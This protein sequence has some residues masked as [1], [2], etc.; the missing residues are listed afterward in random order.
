MISLI[1]NNS[2]IFEIKDKMTTFEYYYHILSNKNDI[3][4]DTISIVMTSSN[5]SKQT[6][7]T[8]NSFKNSLYKNIHVVLVDDSTS[9]PIDFKI[10]SDYPFS[11]DF[12][13]IKRDKKIWVNPCVN[14]NIGF[15]FVKGGKVIIQNAEV[16]HVGDVLSYVNNNVNDSSYYI[17]D[18]KSS[19]GYPSN[20]ELY[21]TVYHTIDTY[22]NT[23]LFNPGIAGWYQSSKYNNR[24]LHFLTAMTLE[25]F[26]LIGGFS[27]D[28]SF[29][30]SYDDNDLVLKIDA[31]NIPTVSVNN[32][33]S[34]C[35]GIHLY[36]VLAG[37]DWE[38][39]IEQ[40]KD[41]FELKM[42]YFNVNKS[43]IEV[44]ESREAYEDNIRK[45]LG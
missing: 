7:Y 2:R 42:Q 14:Y 6:Y 44:T 17:F 26:K 4:T 21:S 12:V 39:N 19:N 43:Y 45:L 23:A 30:G 27:Y 40:N 11:I 9:D 28:Y 34:Q 1:Q 8:L 29:G 33:S 38:R 22:N 3:S 20:D 37:N 32:T 41:L 36:H 25:T 16:F 18:V 15:S 24:R 13:S 5:R 31:K 10:L 35:G